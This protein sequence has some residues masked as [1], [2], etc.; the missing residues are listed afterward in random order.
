MRWSAENFA[1]QACLANE[2]C[3]CLLDT[4][5]QSLAAHRAGDAYGFMQC[6]VVTVVV[7]HVFLETATEVECLPLPAVLAATAVAAV[8]SSS[9][10]TIAAAC[11]RYKHLMTRI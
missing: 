5:V 2:C 6:C 3:N 10:A 1:E 4:C 7:L 9:E 11:V 8:V